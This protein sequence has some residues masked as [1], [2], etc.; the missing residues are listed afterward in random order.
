MKI[1]RYVYGIDLGTGNS[2]IAMFDPETNTV[3]IISKDSRT[4]IPS[5]VYI[6]NNHQAVVG[7]EALNRLG[8]PDSK[9]VI[10]WSKRDIAQ[11]QM[12]TDEGEFI[13]GK[14]PTF[15]NN[16]VTPVIAASFILTVL[17]GMVPNHTEADGP[18]QVVVTFPAHFSPAAKERTRQACLLAGIDVIGMVE[19][20]IA[21]ALHYNA[22]VAHVNRT[23]LSYDWGCGTFDATLIR[24]D[25]HG[26]GK[27]L[28]KG[29]NH[30]L[31]GA[32]CDNCFAYEIWRRYNEQKKAKIDLS[33]EDFESGRLDNMDK[34]RLVHRFRKLANEAKHALTSLEETEVVIDDGDVVV[35][36]TRKMFEDC[37]FGLVEKTLLIVEEVLEEAEVKDT[38][39][40]EVILVGGSSLIPC[41]KTKL[42]AAFPGFSGKMK[43]VDPMECVAKGAA[44]WAHKLAEK[45]ENGAKD[46]VAVS[47]PGRIENTASVS[48]GV[49]CIRN[50]ASGGTET[51][52]S[53]VIIR[54]QSTPAVGK[55]QFSTFHDDQECVSIR[56]YSNR[57][58]DDAVTL[59]DATEIANSNDNRLFFEKKVPK[60]TPLEIEMSMD[61]A[62]LITVYGKSLVDSGSCQF[63]LHLRGTLDS[64]SLEEARKQIA[65]GTVR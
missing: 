62:G 41:V 32:D 10:V 48:L 36:V 52:V 33:R 25:E 7:Q 27:V 15:E 12:F 8:G 63:Q 20:P 17:K 18:I 34:I 58:Q 30:M 54:G 61:D 60:N 59:T 53:N 4:T 47:I 42:E 21:A 22:G 51:Y 2:C 49:E 1:N 64:D 43:L 40:D 55:E 16:Q 45:N 37:I 26:H 65:A 50:V 46:D 6:P 13:G 44:I 28:A 19:E 9:N 57:S 56:I 14:Y 24:F 31:G 38:R 35:G 29:G 39:V 3:Q 5:A 11:D 23:L